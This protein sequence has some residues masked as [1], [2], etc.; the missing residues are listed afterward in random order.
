MRSD[1]LL[2]TIMIVS[3][4]TESA[5]Y[6][7]VIE[8]T[9]ALTVGDVSPPHGLVFSCFMISYMGGSILFGLLSAHASPAHLLIAFSLTSLGAVGGTFF[10]FHSGIAAT[11]S[12]SSF[13]YCSDLSRFAVAKPESSA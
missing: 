12:V 9:P 10:L 4:A 7:F 1:G 11:T 13:R 6:A 8:W 5:M 2:L 3:A